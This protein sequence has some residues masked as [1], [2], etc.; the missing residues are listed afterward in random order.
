M[1]V[2]PQ[3]SNF[4]RSLNPFGFRVEFQYLI[5]WWIRELESLNPFGFRV[6]FQ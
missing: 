4:P 6:E 3:T 1:Q 5:R 2:Y